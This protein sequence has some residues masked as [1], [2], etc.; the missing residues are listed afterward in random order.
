MRG[1]RIR[2]ASA[3][4]TSIPRQKIDHQD[5]LHWTGRYQNWALQC[6]ECHSTNLRKGYDAASDT[7]H[8]TYSEINVACESCHGPASAHVDWAGKAKPR[9]GAGRQGLAVAEEPLE[10]GLE[11][12]QPS[13]RFAVRDQPADPAGMNSLRGLPRPPLDAERRRKAG[14]PLEDSHRLAMLT[15][16]NYHADG[17]QREE[18][19]VWGSFLQSKMHQNGVTC[20]DCH[21][22]HSQKL[23]A[24][25]NALCTR[26]H[27]AAEFDAPKHHQHQ[28]GGKGA[29][30]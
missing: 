6:A 9:P 10:R 1:R 20:M 28:A 7:Y 16:P 29:S 5:P 23:R 14:A 15:A 3:G 2:V 27:N 18:V 13:A 12:P 17:Q 25:G 30:A 24:E 26:C 11:I 22:P 8:T 4:S 21:E 19:Y